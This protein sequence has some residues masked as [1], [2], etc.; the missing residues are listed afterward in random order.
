MGQSLHKDTKG[1]RGPIYGWPASWEYSP[2][3]KYKIKP[4]KPLCL[5]DEDALK[6]FVFTLNFYLKLIDTGAVDKQEVALPKGMNLEGLR[7]QESDMPKPASHLKRTIISLLHKDRDNISRLRYQPTLINPDSIKEKECIEL[8]LDLMERIN[9]GYEKAAS[10]FGLP[11]KRIG[12][13]LLAK[14]IN[15]VCNGK[16]GVY[17]S[18]DIKDSYRTGILHDEYKNINIERADIETL[19]KLI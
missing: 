8:Y 3:S 16:E 13:C 12:N 9:R 2:K 15:A 17:V 5:D 19:S 1:E 7:L 11:Y 18:R 6:F 14:M 4:F 10:N